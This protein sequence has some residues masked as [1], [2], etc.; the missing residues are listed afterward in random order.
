MSGYLTTDDFYIFLDEAS[1][2]TAA[3]TLSGT[4]TIVNGNDYF[5]DSTKA[6]TSDQWEGYCLVVDPGG[7]NEQKRIIKSNTATVLNLEDRILVDS[8]TYS[9]SICKM[10]LSVTNQEDTITK[11]TNIVFVN[12]K[13]NDSDKD[14]IIVSIRTSDLNIGRDSDT[15]A[16]AITTLGNFKDSKLNTEA[17]SILAGFTFG[18][19]DYAGALK[20]GD[21]T[22]NSSTGAITGGSGV[23]VYRS[24]IVGAKSGV[25]TFSI[26]ASTGDA[27]FAGTVEGAEIIGSRLATADSGNFRLVI[28]VETEGGLAAGNII[29]YSALD[30]VLSWIGGDLIGGIGIYADAIGFYTPGAEDMMY[31]DSTAIYSYVDFIIEDKT[32]QLT[33]KLQIPVGTDLY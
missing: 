23:I 32:A 21:I 10:E 8:G 4:G 25:V 20:A 30:A 18:S 17:Q 11:D 7:A 3:A 26:N 28:N 16:T 1:L 12:T 27:T 9:Y 19:T 6:W 29:W 31:M 24:G 14:A 15:L 13:G 22:W 2:P 33:G 5:I